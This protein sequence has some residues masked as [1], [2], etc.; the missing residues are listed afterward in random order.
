MIL[1]ACSGADVTVF[2][3]DSLNM[4]KVLLSLL[5]LLAV[6]LVPVNMPSATAEEEQGKRIVSIDVR[7]NRYVVCA[8][9]LAPIRPCPLS[10]LCA[11]MPMKV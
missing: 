2:A 7:G 5:F 11:N 9:I 6:L 1:R 4:P 8:I 10:I 3:R